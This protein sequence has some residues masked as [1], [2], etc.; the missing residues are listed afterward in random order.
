MA[1]LIWTEP[2]SADLDAIA[3]YLAL[4]DEEAAKR[5]VAKIFRQVEQLLDHPESGSV[6]T[7]LRPDRSYRQIVPT[8]RRTTLSD[9]LSGARKEDL[10]CA[11]HAWGD[12]AQ[13]GLAEN[14][15]VGRARGLCQGSPCADRARRDLQP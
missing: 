2:A 9:M 14:K 11:R 7:E 5:L 13:K 12:F 3:D 4:D 1:Q 15:V 10:H 8:D 6:P